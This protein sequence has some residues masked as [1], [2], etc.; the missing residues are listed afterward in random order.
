MLASKHH[1]GGD[2]SQHLDNGKLEECIARYQAQGDAESLG[3]IIRLS[4]DR[5]LTL[6]RYNGS[7][8]YCPESELLSNINFKL[9]R[10]VTKFDPARGSAFTFLSHVIF[11]TLR[12]SVTSALKNSSRYVELD[13]G[14]AGGLVAS[15]ETEVQHAVDDVV[16]RI[17]RN[18]KTTLR[19]PSEL[20]AQR[21]YVESFINGAFELPRHV[22]ANA[23]MRV[24]GLSH[25]RS[26]EL[27]DLTLL[28]I[29]RLLYDDLKRPEPIAVGRLLGTRCAWMTR[30]Q[31]LLSEAEF[32]KFVVLMR[33]LGPFLLMLIS[34]ESRSRRQDRNPAI[35][36]EN[37]LWIIQG[38]PAAVPLFKCDNL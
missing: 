2:G 21:W 12:T 29:R 3:E 8:R 9:M 18:I 38:H 26:R 19:D 20:E 22:C 5:A 6:I 36:R 11:T 24:C 32:T 35:N 4:Q 13:E 7:A 37:L 34:P 33:G 10:S 27:F 15:G 25:D 16:D 28:E 31:P 30:Y 1:P 23:G 17:R 14:V